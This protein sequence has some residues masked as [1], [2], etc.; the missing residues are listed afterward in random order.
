[1]LSKIWYLAYVEKP[2]AYIIQIIRK[3]I[4]GF[5][6]NYRKDKPNRNIT[7]FPIEMAELAIMDIRTQCKAIQGSILAKF[8]KEKS[9]NNT[10]ADLML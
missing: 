3:D 7:T 6:R 10:L 5:L 1:M 2:P 9:Q 4:H 8:I